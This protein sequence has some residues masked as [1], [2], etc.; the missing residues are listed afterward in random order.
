MSSN[1]GQEPKPD[2]EAEGCRFEPRRAYQL[3]RAFGVPLLSLSGRD[4][5][6]EAVA[7]AAHAADEGD[8]FGSF[9]FLAEPEDVDV[10][11][12]VG[13]GAVVAPHGV[14]QLLAAEHHAGEL[15]RNSRPY[16]KSYNSKK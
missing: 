7:E 2:F 16:A 5:D 15:I 9:D 12:A 3:F 14:Q 6:V 11:G 10:D 1:S 13:D 8:A 4:L